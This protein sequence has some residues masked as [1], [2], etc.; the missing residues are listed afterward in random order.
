MENISFPPDEINEDYYYLVEAQLF[1]IN[2]GLPIEDAL[3]GLIRSQVSF[4]L[5]QNTTDDYFFPTRRRELDLGV[6]FSGGVLGGDFN[7]IR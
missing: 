5:S 3:E 6:A 7:V 1:G 2:P 4:R